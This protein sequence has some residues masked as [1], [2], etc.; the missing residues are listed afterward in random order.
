[1]VTDDTVHMVTT[2]ILEC[3][4]RQV[5]MDT[6]GRIREGGRAVSHQRINLEAVGHR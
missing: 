4:L 5:G 2:E 1:M 6:S 3:W